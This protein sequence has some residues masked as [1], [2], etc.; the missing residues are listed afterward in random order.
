MDASKNVLWLALAVAVSTVALTLMAVKMFLP[1]NGQSV[2]AQ[3]IMVP[4]SASEQERLQ[5]LEEKIAKLNRLLT[6]QPKEPATAKIDSDQLQELQA[7]VDD[8]SAQLEQANSRE[9][10]R[11]AF[12]QELRTLASDPEVQQHYRDVAVQ[13][14]QERQAAVAQS[15]VQEPV[16]AAWADATV[17]EVEAQLGASDLAGV[18]LVNVECRSTACRVDVDV[19]KLED[20]DATMMEYE[21]LH[22]LKGV[23]PQGTVQKQALADGSYQYSFLLNREGFTTAR[24]HAPSINEVY[25]RVRAE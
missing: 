17:A 2:V 3:E 4:A 13:Q 16:D 12:H 6:N 8:M 10:E 5:K 9:Q 24:V 25:S 18:N 14:R 1:V 23:L 19:S 20:T 7:K 21:I 22:R 15:F 11:D